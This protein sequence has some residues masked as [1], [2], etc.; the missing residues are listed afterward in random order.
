METSLHLLHNDELPLQ[1]VVY[2]TL[3]RAILLG[4]LRPGD[5]LLELRLAK[6]L[7]VS[8]TPIREAIRK[9]E[10]ESLVV[11]SP[12]KGTQVASITEKDMN[13]VLEV[14]CAL[15]E[16]AVELSC[17]R[18]SKEGLTELI[19][20]NDELKKAVA[21]GDLS[22]SAQK[23]AAFHDVIYHAS[24]NQQLISM[25]NN[26]RLR[27]YRYRIE[28]LKEES[29]HETLIGEHALLIKAIE[30]KEVERAK[31]IIKSHIYNQE[32]TIR[33]NLNSREE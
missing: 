28:Y 23:D 11:M 22:L 16:L 20:R 32:R 6:Q 17:E 33:R 7:G 24:N 8:R 2:Q 25:L 26:L 21:D 5:R 10:Q 9:L 3:E 31:E 29:S 15:E 4:E 1:D 13:D 30:K 14:R 12:R 27:M 19:Q 18:I